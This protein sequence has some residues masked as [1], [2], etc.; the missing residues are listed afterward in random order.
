[1]PPDLLSFFDLG[2]ALALILVGVAFGIGVL[3]HLPTSLQLGPVQSLFFLAIADVM[4]WVVIIG[5]RGFRH[6]QNPS[7]YPGWYLS[8]GTL[9]MF[10]VF[11]LGAASGIAVLDRWERRQRRIAVE[12]AGVHVRIK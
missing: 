9:L 10:L 2:T 3:G 11:D 12:L 8:I 1:M 4:P 7:L 5:F 6:Y